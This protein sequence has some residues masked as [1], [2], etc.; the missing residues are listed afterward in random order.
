MDLS[1]SYLGFQL[2]HPF[3]PGASP[4]VDSLD[5]VKRLED[6]GAA[7][8]VMHSLFQEQ[9]ESGAP[10]G[11]ARPAN[12]VDRLLSAEPTEFALTPEQYLHQLQE[13]KKTVAVPVIASL[14]GTMAEE[15][16]ESAKSI[17]QAGADALELNIY[18]LAADPLESSAEVDRR[19]LHIARKV[20]GMVS[21]PI[22]VKL[23]V[24]I[25]GVSNVAHDLDLIG[26][27]GLVLFN[28]FY[29]PDIDIERLVVT[30]TL[31]L[32]DSS[33]LLVRLRWLAILSPDVRASLAV[34]GG[35][36]TVEDAV[37]ALMAGASAVQVVS[38]LLKQG[39]EHLTTL[40]D[41][42][43]SWLEQQEYGSLREIQG[44][45]NLKRCPTA[46]A[47]ERANYTRVLQSW[48][49]EDPEVEN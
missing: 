34:S 28:R 35:V 8:I 23:S 40:R 25:S 10:R 42:L 48:R 29:Q 41:G 47:Y 12:F 2:P 44:I 38:A 49:A 27:N 24:F 46:P 7:A 4:L 32:S 30:P 21:I 22:A 11:T 15:W 5:M 9:L 45:M 33:E 43:A 37:K 1:T 17:E 26:V 31:K 20:R 39:P 36:H 19:I 13:I 16:L 6:A 14:N 3:M 18:Y